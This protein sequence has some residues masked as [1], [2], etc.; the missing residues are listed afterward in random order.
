LV[1][2]RDVVMT[3]AKFYLEIQD[4]AVKKSISD[5]IGKLHVNMR[6][7]QISEAFI[8]KELIVY[9]E[10]TDKILDFKDEDQHTREIDG[11]PVDLIGNDSFFT[12]SKVSNTYK[13][14]ALTNTDING[15]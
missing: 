9:Y 1:D 3:N 11:I 7:R 15:D 4:P 8:E 5:K 12:M 13:D 10:D 14:L 6:E 2:I